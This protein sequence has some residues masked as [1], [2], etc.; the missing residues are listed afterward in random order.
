MPI[1]LPSSSSP[2]AQRGTRAQPGT[3]VP[4]RSAP[5]ASAAGLGFGALDIAVA[6][7][8]VALALLL[9]FVVQF[10]HLSAVL[11]WGDS[12]TQGLGYYGLPAAERDRFKRRLRFHSILLYPTLRLLGRLSK[13]KFPAASFVHDGV[14]GPKGTCSAESFARGVAYRP[15]PDDVFVVTQMKCGTTWMQNLVYEIL[16]RGRGDLVATGR[17]MYSV[18]PWLEAQ[19]SVGVEEAPLHGEER[20]RR[21]IKT[22]LPAKLCPFDE[23]ACYIYVARHPVSCFAS[24]VDFIAT[25][26][27]AFAPPLAVIE[28]WYCSEEMWW[29]SWPAHVAGWWELSQRHPN[30]LFLRFEDMKRDLGAVADRVADFLGVAPLAAAERAQVLHKCSFA[31]MKEHAGSFEMHPPH[32]LQ[33]DAELFISGKADRHADVPADV[34]ERVAAWCRNALASSAIPLATLYPEA[35]ASR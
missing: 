17:T 19:K 18:S 12:R 3:P 26:V 4:P 15:S 11:A 31:Y 28:E 2:R 1:G 20:P 13:M 9:L 10:I 25:N 23:Q 34:R 32:L 27:G 16:M 21:I 5:L 14:A 7:G 22:H 35:A 33:T 30:V 29:G 8:L 6:L 24:C